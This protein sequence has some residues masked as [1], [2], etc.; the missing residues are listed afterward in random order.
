MQPQQAQA[1]YNKALAA[2]SSNGH[3]HLALAV[4]NAHAVWVASVQAQLPALIAALA[5]AQANK[6]YAI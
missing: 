4:A 6:T 5:T 2:Y 3:A 1:A